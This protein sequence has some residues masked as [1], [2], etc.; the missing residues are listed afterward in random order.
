[1]FIARSTCLRS[2]HFPFS[3]L[4]SA[5]ASSISAKCF[6]PLSLMC[7]SSMEKPSY[8]I[9]RFETT[10]RRE[11]QY[12][13]GSTEESYLKELVAKVRVGN[14]DDEVL[15]CLLED[16]TCFNIQISNQL[17][18]KLLF[19]F[20]DDW[21]SALGFFRWAGSRSGY[22]HTT[23]AYD[24]MV[25]ILGKM[26]QMDR[27]WLLV[28][29]MHR[30]HLVTLKTVAK[31]IRRL[32]GAGRWEDAIKTF[33]DLDTLGLEKNTESMNLLLDTL[34]KER[35]VELAREVYLKLKSHISPNAHTFTIFIHGW[36]KANRVDEAH[37][38]IQ[39]MK[40]HGFRPCV[41]SYSTIIQAYCNQSNFRKVFELLDEMKAQGCP[42]N[43]VTY[44]TIIYSLAKSDEFEASL[45]L[46]KE[47]I[48]IGCKPDTLFYNALI[49]IL[50]RAGQ[51]QEAVH[52]FEEEMP[53]NGISPNSSTYNTMIAMFCHHSQ[54]QN[55]LHVLKQLEMSTICKPD[56]QTYNPLL[57]M[58]IKSGSTDHSLGNLLN[59]M[60]NKH[61]LSLDLSTYT[62]LLHGLCRANKCEWACRIFEEMMSQDITPRYQT[63]S[64]LLDAVKQNR[65]DDIAERVEAV[66]RK[67]KAS[68]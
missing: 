5:F 10:S 57:K 22:K 28:A 37:W 36:C 44:T 55:A 60:V 24:K 56:L 13:Q 35:K 45:Q 16:Q 66:M 49:H 7:L 23:E 47:M 53:M 51:V 32:A 68:S 26:K 50:G 9:K 48:S 58:C 2:T 64:L 42:P 8:S 54:E 1:M 46:S 29:E 3:L 33:D 52:V 67:M 62:L 65:L 59:E 4:S 12:C 14:S 61:H 40:G 27:M 43:V 25:D 11:E 30:S 39:E 20:S 38:T 6:L 21:K 19:R 18:D 15:H 34:C 63:C 17:V 31:V 41:I